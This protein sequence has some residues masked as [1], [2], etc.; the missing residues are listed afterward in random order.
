M[1]RFYSIKSGANFLITRSDPSCLLFDGLKDKVSA[2]MDWKKNHAEEMRSQDFQT[3]LR[4][5]LRYLILSLERGGTDKPMTLAKP[6][7]DYVAELVK[8]QADFKSDAAEK[9]ILSKKI[10]DSLF[11]HW[12][13]LG[14]WLPSEK[15]WE[16]SPNNVSGILEKNIRRP[17][18]EA[19]DPNLISVWDFEI[20]TRNE[21]IS[22]RGSRDY[23]ANQFKTI[24]LPK[25]QFARANDLV[26]LGMNNRG[27]TEIF[28]LIKANPQ[29]PDFAAWLQ[30]LR[31][32][33]TP[34][35]KEPPPPAPAS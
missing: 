1:F 32:L 10:N 30:R 17:L 2:F 3:A 27:I 18:R 6:S 21:N 9:E 23:D 33:L 16:S 12:L 35:E 20:Q 34:A 13:K 24:E 29:H 19:K 26:A 15:E 8:A 5:H 7:M 22:K 25:L 4:L 14:Q 31:E 11:T 28:A